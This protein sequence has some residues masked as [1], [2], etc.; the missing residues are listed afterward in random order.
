[1]TIALGILTPEWSVL[2]AD[3]QEGDG[4]TKM[5]VG[6]IALFCSP[7][8]KTDDI[9]IARSVAL[10]GAGNSGYLNYMA[11]EIVR[12]FRDSDFSVDD[13]EKYLK[14]KIRKFHELHVP[15]THGQTIELV[16]TAQAFGERRMWVTHLSTTR[17]VESYAVIGI[18]NT[19]A[20]KALDG[21]IPGLVDRNAAAVIAAYAAF[22]A[23][24]HADGCGMDTSVIAI[25]R[26]GMMVFADPV[27]LRKL[28][29]YFREY[30]YRERQS[31]LAVPGM[32]T[33]QSCAAVNG[34]AEFFT[35]AAEKMSSL[36]IFHDLDASSSVIELVS[37]DPQSTKAD[38]SLLPLTH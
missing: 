25:R 10:T 24:Q 21:F 9:S 18:G 37:Q 23:K 32:R 8:K 22:T 11:T 12:R 30:D 35:G 27:S 3:S 14:T 38:P 34:A 5:D 16:V 1:M 17:R 28:E 7:C 31:R 4:I 19:W 6:K 15:L 29:E 2:A 36:N 33:F 26:D 13:F 20:R